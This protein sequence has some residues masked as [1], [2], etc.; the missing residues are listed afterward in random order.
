MNRDDQHF[1]Q[2]Q[3]N[4]RTFKQRWSTFPK[5]STKQKTVEAVIINKS[6]NV[7]K[8][9]E[10]LNSDGQTVPTTSTKQKNI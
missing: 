4:K 1:Y 10:H 5:T 8:T 7:N 3:Q 9:K 6:T 2:H